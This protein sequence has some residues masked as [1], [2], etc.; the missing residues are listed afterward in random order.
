MAF[1]HRDWLMCD[2]KAAEWS[3]KTMIEFQCP[4]CGEMMSVPDSLV[5][6]AETCPEC[7]NV[8]IV[9]APQTIGAGMRIQSVAPVRLARLSVAE[10]FDNVDAICPNCNHGLEKRPG[11]KKKCPHCGQFIYVRTRP[12][13]GKK[14]L[15]TEAQAEQIAEQWFISR[16]GTHDEFLSEQRRLAE[17]KERVAGR[18]AHTKDPLEIAR[19][20]L[21]HGKNWPEVARTIG[22]S[23]PGISRT[24]ADAFTKIALTEWRRTQAER[25]LD[26]IE[27]LGAEEFEVK[28]EWSTA[29]DDGV[30]HACAAMEGKIFTVKGARRL[31]PHAKCTSEDGCR[32]CWTPAVE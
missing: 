12:S 11:R 31:M 6:Q 9:S 29:G 13:D 26:Q 1:H 14:V 23:I 25:Q 4:K 32:C 2:A 7:G 15:A 28:V 21:A 17:E 22:K 5:G 20:L 19:L 24:E 18:L 27:A 30:C 8:A 3:K 10:A 16:G